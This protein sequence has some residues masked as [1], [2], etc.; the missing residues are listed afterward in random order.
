MK[1]DAQQLGWRFVV[2]ETLGNHSEGKGLD[3]SDS[4]VACATV[5]K[6]AGQVW[7]FGDPAAVV[8]TFELDP[9]RQAHTRYCSTTKA[10]PDKR[11]NP[12]GATAAHAAY[13]L[14]GLL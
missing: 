2:F 5:A 10:L 3:T 8:L 12:T 11:L 14:P 13:C 7:N 6:D 4:L 9:I 1:R